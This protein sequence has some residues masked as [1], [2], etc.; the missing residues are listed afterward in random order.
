MTSATKTKLLFECV[1]CSRCGG[2]GE[3][4]YRSFAGK[5]CF[6][7]RGRGWTFTKR[8]E[9]AQKVY[10]N[11][12]HVS[13]EQLKVGDK[14]W[15]QGFSFGS[16]GTPGQWCEIQ[17]IK[18]GT[19]QELKGGYVVGREHRLHYVIKTSHI[20]FCGE[21]GDAGK[22]RKAWSN[23]QKAEFKKQALEYQARLTK[24]GAL[25]KRSA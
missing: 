4:W 25:R 11:L 20:S 3:F 17:E 8:G 13:L 9:A 7:C 15:N 16:G 18:I 19:V 14:I 2:T 24:T 5:H 23:E 6:K 1:E 22:F 10:S 12:L 21:I